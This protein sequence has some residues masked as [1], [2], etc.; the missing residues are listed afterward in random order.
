LASSTE[1]FADGAGA[2]AQFSFPRD[3]AVDS[4]GNA[5]VGDTNNHLIR[6]ITPADRI[7]DRVVSTLAGSGTEGFANGTGNTA[8]FEDPYDLAVDSSGNI[9]VTDSDNHRI[10]KIE[11]KVP[12]QR[13]DGSSCQCDIF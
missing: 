1:G 7:E 3:V 4:S 5:Y 9:Y 10:R 2:A 8:Q 13:R 12:W 6:K 11:Y